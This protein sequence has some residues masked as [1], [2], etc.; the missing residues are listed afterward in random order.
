MK[1]I[2]KNTQTEILLQQNKLYWFTLN[3]FPVQTVPERLIRN[4]QLSLNT[5]S[6]SEHS[7][8]LRS[9]SSNQSAAASLVAG[10]GGDVERHQAVQHPPDCQTHGAPVKQAVHAAP[11]QV[12]RDAVW[13]LDQRERS[14]TSSQRV[15]TSTQLLLSP[16]THL[17][18]DPAGGDRPPQVLLL[19]KS[20]TPETTAVTRVLTP[21]DQDTYQPFTETQFRSCSLN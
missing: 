16:Q 5:S 15:I 3:K 21:K 13:P 14:V 9:L 20:V 11:L 18:R 4:L 17:S 12:D 7:T 6:A 1:G 19:H 8:F 2:S 10:L